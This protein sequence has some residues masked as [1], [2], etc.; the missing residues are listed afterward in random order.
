MVCTKKS[1]EEYGKKNKEIA[2]NTNLLIRK[3]EEFD[4]Y[5]KNLL[6]KIKELNEEK[7]KIEVDENE[8]KKRN[9][10]KMRRF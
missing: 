9:R 4:K 1:I 8:K 10:E 3:Y 6:E 5:N 7:K 2:E